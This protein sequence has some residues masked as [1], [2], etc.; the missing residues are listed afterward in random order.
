VSAKSHPGETN[1]NWRGGK[2]SHPLYWIHADMIARCRRPSH[3]RYADYGGRGITVCDRWRGRDGFWHFVADMGP[4]PEGTTPAGRPL[5][6]LDR[7]DNDRGYEPDNCR[8]ATQSQQARNR[9]RYGWED[10]AR[11]LATGQ[12]LPKEAS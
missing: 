8:W 5:Y 7:I 2:M 10:R 1:S 4:R 12:F 11:D 9:R 3:L 6:T